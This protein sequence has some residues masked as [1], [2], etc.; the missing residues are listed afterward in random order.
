M[1]RIALT[2]G[3]GLALGAG[4]ISLVLLT[5]K[6]PH[7]E[8]NTHRHED[9]S[10]APEDEG[11]VVLTEEA[12]KSAGIV[13]TTVRKQKIGFVLT[14]TAIVRPNAD[15]LAHV[16]PRITGRVIE[17]RA[18]QGSQVKRGDPLLVLDS[19]EA[20]TAAAEF[21]KAKAAVEVAK[22]NYEREEALM[23]RNA[24]RGVD[25][26]TAKGDL[27]RAQ[28]EFEAAREKLI[29]LGWSA[30]HVNALKWDDPEGLSR[31]TIQ[32][33]FD[34]EIIEKHATLGEVVNPG[35][36]LFT[37]ANL[38]TVWVAID[39]YQKD[40]QHIHAGLPVE[41][42]AE[43]YPGR[44]FK[45]KVAYVGKV[46]VE[47]TRTLEVRVELDNESGR[48][49]PGMFVSAS[50]I[51]QEE[52]HSSELIAVLD[53]AVQ[54]IDNVPVVFV[55]KA[56]GTYERRAVTLGKRLGER[57]A[58]LAGLEDGETVVTEG[59]FILKSELLRSRMGHGHAH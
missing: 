12:R 57:H 16:S 55:A 46:F 26:Y 1:R 13:S 9:H 48:L 5:R 34:G 32:A 41:A 35:V 29:L 45:G 38:S 33:P 39:I 20:G 36:N 4:A 25:F 40:V 47:E 52:E 17:I 44:I 28:A 27:V 11:V 22:I 2:F 10:K 37:I 42:T 6:E 18:V 3:L 19:I 24:T 56:P 51:C 50:V 23:K 7:A 14:A 21:L 31:V 58:V 15:Q 59:S 30:D 53:S 49:R 8:E 54:R 43:G